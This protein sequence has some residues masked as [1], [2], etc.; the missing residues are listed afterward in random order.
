MSRVFISYRRDDSA[1]VTGR[2]FDKLRSHFEQDLVVFRDVDFIPLGRDFREV[3]TEA[4]ESCAVL[5]AVI[6]PSWVDHRNEDG[7]RRLDDPHDFVRLE[8]ETALKRKIPVVP[9][10]VSRARMPK[11]AQL[12][13]SLE[14][15]AFR[16]GLEV[17]R[18]PDFHHDMDRLIRALTAMLLKSPSEVENK[19]TQEQLEQEAREKAEKEA[20]AK[21]PLNPAR[22][23][24]AG[25]KI[26]LKLPGDVPIA[27]AWCPPGTFQMGSNDE[28][29]VR[30]VKLTKGFY[31]A[32]YPITQAQWKAVMGTEPSN[33]KG[34][35]RPVEQVSWTDAVEFCTK[36]TV[37]LSGRVQVRLPTEAEW[38]YACRAGTVT[39]YYAG[40]GESA[41]QAVGWYDA[42]S[43]KETHPV[44]Q[45]E[46]NAWNLQDMHG[47]VWEWCNDWYG[48]YSSAQTTDP[49]G[50]ASGSYRVNRGGSWGNSAGR[51]RSAYRDGYDP[52]DRGSLL[53]FRAALVLKGS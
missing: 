38:E 40:S 8:I 6:G 5:L 41:L 51:C 29:P 10:L 45:L 39:D 26:A 43:G 47:N 19:A 2:I 35:D 30:T 21:D 31:M 15:L 24:T 32:V 28:K 27:F 12:P 25:E 14:P 4:V 9:L 34:A 23:R 52:T 33:F 20:K 22:T 42:N 46:A 18:D 13:G 17:R 49:T 48:E 3:I 1:D 37:K 7:E 36:L 53:G 11:A 50:P 44:G 16:N